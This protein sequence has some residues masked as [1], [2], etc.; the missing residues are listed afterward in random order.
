MSL[1]RTGCLSCCTREQKKPKQ[2]RLFGK[3]SITK[4][5]ARLRLRGGRRH[6]IGRP[7]AGLQHLSGEG[8]G[9]PI[10]TPPQINWAAR[11]HAGLSGPVKVLAGRSHNRAQTVLNALRIRDKASNRDRHRKESTLLAELCQVRGL[12]KPRSVTLATL[13]RIMCTKNQP[14]LPSLLVKSKE[15]LVVLE[16]RGT[17]TG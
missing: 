17:Q 5:P 15:K 2:K 7:S 14:N 9:Q 6:S 12:V 4:Q 8:T 16:S 13:M 11:N 10:R 3:L 1:A